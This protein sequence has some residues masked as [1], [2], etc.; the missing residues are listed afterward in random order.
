M[1]DGT[2]PGGEGSVKGAESKRD[3]MKGPGV[4]NDAA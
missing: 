1:T 4:F 2:K 3:N